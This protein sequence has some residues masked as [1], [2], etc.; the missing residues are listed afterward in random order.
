MGGVLF[1][2]N[3]GT[4][5]DGLPRFC[6][7][8]GNDLSAIVAARGAA[9][10]PA[11]AETLAVP[12][13]PAPQASQPPIAQAPAASI[14]AGTQAPAAPLPVVPPPVVPPQA[15]PPAWSVPMSQ[16]QFGSPQFG[17]PPAQP[18]FG[19]P[20]PAPSFFG[21]MPGYQ[22]PSQPGMLAARPTG[23]TIL[24]ILEIVVGVAGLW[25]A[26]VLWDYADLRRYW[27]GDAGSYQILALV[28]AASAVAAFF[29]AWGLWEIKPWA[30]LLGVVLCLLSI[31]SGLLNA[32]TYSDSI[33]SAAI[34][35]AI[36]GIVLYY[37]N[38]NTIRAL[39]GRPPTTLLQPQPA[40]GPQGP[41]PPQYPR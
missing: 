27:L 22:A 25:A 26:K 41:Q 8:C 9:A 12:P 24:A 39:F 37:L 36:N 10:Q 33:A 3:C 31:A 38:L 11:A 35:V 7:A 28:T 16:P 19:A 5:Q 14:T 4:R 29:L 2:P 30:W 21:G 20:P 17:P 1:C 34:G 15:A 32:F 13:A 40:Q 6:Y 18:G 23:I